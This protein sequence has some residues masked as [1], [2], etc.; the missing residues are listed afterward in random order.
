MDTFL[1]VKTVKTQFSFWGDKFPRARLLDHQ[2]S[3]YL[4]LE[5]AVRLFSRVAL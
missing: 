5:E 2:I 3:A 4:V 1:L